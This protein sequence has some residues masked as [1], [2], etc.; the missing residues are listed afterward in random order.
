MFGEV[1][2]GGVRLSHAVAAALWIGGTLVYGLLSS[3]GIAA[4]PVN[5]RAFREALRQSRHPEELESLR[6]PSTGSSPWGS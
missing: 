4:S 1:L 5:T 2:L 6:G 3:G